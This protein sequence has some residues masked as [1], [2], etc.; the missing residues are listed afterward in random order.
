MLPNTGQFTAAIQ[1]QD[2][3]ALFTIL[4]T[5]NA[6]SGHFLEGALDMSRAGLTGHSMGGGNTVA[7][8]ASNPGY[9]AGFC[10]APLY[11]GSATTNQVRVPLGIVHGKGDTVLPWRQHGLPT[12]DNANK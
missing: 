4:Q 6:S 10:F 9:L 11:Q 3:I 12:F 1:R 5:I 7:V 8:L 2:S